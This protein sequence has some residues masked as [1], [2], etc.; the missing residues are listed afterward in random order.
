M[1]RN[2]SSG[3]NDCSNGSLTDVKQNPAIRLLTD[4]IPAYI[5]PTLTLGSK[6][7]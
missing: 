6:V 4:S 7:D 5:E 3:R 2:I 1:Q